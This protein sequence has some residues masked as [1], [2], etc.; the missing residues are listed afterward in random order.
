MSDDG[1]TSMVFDSIADAYLGSSELA[2]CFDARATLARMLEFEAAL[3]HAQARLGMIPAQA[4]AH[5]AA[6]CVVDYYDIEAI[7]CETAAS[8]S[9][10]IPVVNA[11]TARVAARDPSAALYVHW[12]SSTQDVMDSALMLQARAGLGA[13]LARL[14]HI[15]DSLAALTRG[16]HETL[17]VA[18]T[19]SQ[20]ALPTTFGYKCGLWLEAMV[21]AGVE[22]SRLGRALPVQFGGA[23]GTLAAYGGRGLALRDALASDLGLAAVLPW[24]TDRSVIRALAAGLAMTA[25][26]A[27]K[28]ANDLLLM[29]QSEVGELREAA[30]P[31]RGGSTALPHKRNPVAAIAVTAGA[32]R[33]PGQLA[34]LFACFDHGHERAS[35][36]WHAEWQ[37]LRELFVTLGAMLEQLDTALR[38]IEVN[39]VAMRANLESSR[40]LVMA[41]AVVMALAVTLGRSA[42]QALVKRAVASAAADD[43]PLYDVLCE[44]HAVVELLGREGLAGAMDPRAYLGSS[45]E[46]VVVILARYAAWRAA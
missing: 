30:G 20:H 12:G 27:G 8:S 13:L 16:H 19:L 40:G 7:K 41:E 4:A 14:G 33:V 15:A 31:G 44:E 45:A 43:R 37:S 18:R 26:S 6:E 22:L 3:A 39:T 36:A 17:M 25:A 38:G 21:S 23:A 32:H 9:A 2:A 46:M 1:M 35:G 10:A 29:M 34:A 5:I 11:L 28:L 24:H 42:A